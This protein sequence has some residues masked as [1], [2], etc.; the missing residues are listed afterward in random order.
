DIVL[1]QE[2]VDGVDLVKEIFG[3]SNFEFNYKITQEW[4]KAWVADSMIC[5]NADKFTRIELEGES[6]VMGRTDERNKTKS[7][8]VRLREI[9]TQKIID[10]ASIHAPGYAITNP[11]EQ[12]VA[13]GNKSVQ[14]IIDVFKT[15]VQPSN[16]SIV[17]GDFNSESN[18]DYI[19]NQKLLFSQRRF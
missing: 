15:C 12:N 4:N 18:P 19:E 7:A 16:I 14:L 10:I 9:A 5:W 13:N 2:V 8:I 11:T 1:L 6:Q 17:A 3:K